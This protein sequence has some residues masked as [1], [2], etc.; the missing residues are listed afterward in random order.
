MSYSPNVTQLKGDLPPVNEEPKK[1]GHLLREAG[2]LT[3][4]DAG[5]VLQAQK[6]ENLR[7][8]EIAIKLGFIN[9]LDLQQALS[10][11]FS[12]PSI[13]PDDAHF[14]VDLVAAYRP[15]GS[16][17][18]QLRAM[19]GQLMLRW[20]SKGHKALVVAGIDAGDG[21][22]YLAANLAVVF[23]QLGERTLLIDADLRRPR[24][25]ALFN[26]GNRPG[27]SD[28]LAGRCDASVA[29]RIPAFPR[30][31]VLTAGA[32]PPNSAE[33]L[34]RPT[35]PPQLEALSR[36][37]DVVLIDTAA[38]ADGADGAM[39]AARI[40][41]ALLVLRQD[42]TRLAAAAAFRAD[43]ESNGAVLVGAVLNQH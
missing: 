13:A 4:A 39:L 28:F 1:V 37:Y 16:Q 25:H 38:A 24:Q 29:A 36:N 17:I 14:S 18:E 34:A 2:K 21:A 30:L 11:Q 9:E 23:S 22:S 5:R 31:A 27:L 19:R 33:L 42:H 6:M 15:A 26:L 43:L 41:G 7:F 12:I 35:T 20:F 10:Q 40:G 8:G 32:V 3:I